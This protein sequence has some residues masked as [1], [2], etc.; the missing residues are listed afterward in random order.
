MTQLNGFLHQTGMAPSD[1]YT[2][3]QA[4]ETVV[5]TDPQLPGDINEQSM[6]STGSAL[7]AEDAVAVPYHRDPDPV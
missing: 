4:K 5:T 1:Q 2:Y 6:P 7:H 3:G